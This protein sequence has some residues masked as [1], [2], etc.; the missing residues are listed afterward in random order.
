MRY[1][2]ITLLILLLASP[3]LAAETYSDAAALSQ[4][5]QAITNSF[6]GAEPIRALPYPTAP[7]VT[8]RGGPSY[9]AAPSLDTGPQFIPVSQLVQILNAV[10][11]CQEFIGDDISEDIEAYI[12]VFRRNAVTE[13][14]GI[15][16]EVVTKDTRYSP[17]A[18]MAV[19]S[20][21]THEEAVTS[22]SLAAQLCKIAREIGASKVIFMKEGVVP[23]LDSTGWGIGM[24]NSI[25]VVNASPTGIGGF[26][27][28]GT[29]YS[30]GSAYYI[31]L[32]YLIV[33]FVE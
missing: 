1:I 31:K 11:T 16:F 4:Q 29:G 8:Q 23:M 3:V 24:G 28:S 2:G 27:S 5:R 32:P 6:N 18:P 10:D 25:N 9:F 21:T 19:G 26:A 12:T 14:K 7:P 22:A 17:L 33:T 20:V 30:T 13:C 15:K